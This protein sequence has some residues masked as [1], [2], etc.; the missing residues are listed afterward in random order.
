M[1]ISKYKI[2]PDQAPVLVLT[3]KD[4]RFITGYRIIGVFPNVTGR[5]S[6]KALVDSVKILYGLML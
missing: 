2:K 1:D 4:G 6:T 5:K 3:D